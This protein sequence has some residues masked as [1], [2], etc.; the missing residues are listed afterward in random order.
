M[1]VVAWGA[2]IYYGVA[3]YT[4]AFGSYKQLLPLGLFQ[5]A[6]Q[7]SIAVLG[8]LLS[9]AGF[10]NVYAAP[11][12]SFGGQ[13]QWLHVVAHFTI[14]ILVPSLLFWGLA[15]LVLLVTKKMA[16]RRPGAAARAASS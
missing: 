8:I 10:P 9:L 12:Y 13:S 14:G 1:N 7:Q 11:E 6:L 16:A 3:V 4:R 15:S 5:T 2:A